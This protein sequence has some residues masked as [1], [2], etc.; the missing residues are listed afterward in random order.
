MPKQIP[1][2]LVV[3]ALLKGQQGGVLQGEH[4]EGRHQGVR[5]G[6][7]ALPPA[8]VGDLL[9]PKPQQFVQGIGGKMLAHLGARFFGRGRQDHGDSFRL[10]DRYHSECQQGGILQGEHGESRH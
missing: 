2:V 1:Q 5:Q 4:G 3:A 7:R 10:V 8:M 9:K 6:N